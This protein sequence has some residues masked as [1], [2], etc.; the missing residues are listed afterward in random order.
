MAQGDRAQ[1]RQ[2]TDRGRTR[3]STGIFVG[4]VAGVGTPLPSPRIGIA[5]RAALAQRLK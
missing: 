4:T 2:V 1:N 3:V 5:R